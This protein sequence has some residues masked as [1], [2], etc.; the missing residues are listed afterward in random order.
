MT[1]VHIRGRYFCSLFNQAL[2][3]KPGNGYRLNWPIVFGRLN[4]HE[5]TGG[6]LTATLADL[7]AI[8]TSVIVAN[9]QI[10]IR[11]LKV[12]LLFPISTLP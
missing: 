9:F 1:D 5:G 8:W 12:I 2:H 11:D 3:V 4:I 10:P 6:S 7:E